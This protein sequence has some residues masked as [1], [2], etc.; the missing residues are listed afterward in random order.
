MQL[1]RNVQKQLSKD[2]ENNILTQFSAANRATREQLG[3]IG[4]ANKTKK[5]CVTTLPPPRSLH[6]SGLGIIGFAPIGHEPLNVFKHF[7]LKISH[8]LDGLQQ[9]DTIPN[10]NETT[11]LVRERAALL[12]R[13]ISSRQP[14]YQFNWKLGNVWHKHI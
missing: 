1:R 10:M 5:E 12:L 7:D 2:Y 3:A 4:S 9:S 11:L 8:S 6:T 13:A 14:R